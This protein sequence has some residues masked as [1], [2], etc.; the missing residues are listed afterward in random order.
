MNVN[1]KIEIILLILINKFDPIKKSKEK[2][3]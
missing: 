3:L 1:E 2:T